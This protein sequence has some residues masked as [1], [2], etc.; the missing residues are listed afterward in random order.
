MQ[1]QVAKVG[2]RMKLDLRAFNNYLD[3]ESKGQTMIRNS[4]HSPRLPDVSGM[5][6]YFFEPG[7]ARNAYYNDPKAIELARASEKE[8]DPTK[9]KALIK[10]LS[11]YNADQA[12]VLPIVS[13]VVKFTHT[14]D[15]LVNP[16]GRLELFG[17]YMS[18]LNWKK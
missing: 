12:Y 3:K 2:F 7:A 14:S 10:Q 9:R 17:F 13:S 11:D 18:D 16:R 6:R 1:A 8:M 4:M 5:T 15:I